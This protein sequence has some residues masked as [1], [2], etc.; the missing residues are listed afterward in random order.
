M[1]PKKLGFSCLFK[2]VFSSI[3]RPVSFSHAKENGKRTNFE[4]VFELS[5]LRYQSVGLL[6]KR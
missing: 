1:I 2:H 3:S 5:V 4:S 6:V